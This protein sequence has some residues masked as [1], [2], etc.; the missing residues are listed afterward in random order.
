MSKE[1]RAKVLAAG[2]SAFL[3]KPISWSDLASKLEEC[4]SL[5]WLYEEGE[6]E[7]EETEAFALPPKAKLEELARF[8]K[9]GSIDN[10]N[11]WAK[12]LASESEHYQP[13][14]R[15]LLELSENFDIKGVHSL[16]NRCLERA[17]S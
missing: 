17:E 16:V 13:L 11:D 10:I 2:Y 8:A 7:R 1:D 9:M 4:L 6:S 15:A 5:Q 14:T 3:D 12:Q